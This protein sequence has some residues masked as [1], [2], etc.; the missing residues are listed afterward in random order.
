MVKA[1]GFKLLAV[2]LLAGVVACDQATDA[3]TGTA[4]KASI[5]TTATPANKDWTTV[6]AAT[7]EGGFRM[8]NPAA[9]VKLIE[10]ASLTCPHCR[11][12]HET[13]MTTIKSK[14]VATGR[15]SYEYRNFVLNGPDYA[16][17]LLA[18][19]QGAAPFFNLANAF[20]QSQAQWTEPFTRLTPADNTAMQA[21]PADRQMQALALKGGLD[22]FMRTRG[23]T[24]AKFDQCLT[25]KAAQDKLN[26]MRTVAVEKYGLTGTP[27]FII[28]E[29]TQKDISGWA[30]LEP[31]LQAALN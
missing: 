2:A 16:A 4:T 23:M 19:C 21:L 3:K 9:P 27:S 7:P 14:Y 24:R 8:G 26:A 15:V 25:D 13:A 31:K 30:Q 6:V 1:N 5:T 12:F 10:Y 18:R 29:A 20:Y 17:S 11:D 22:G 28:N